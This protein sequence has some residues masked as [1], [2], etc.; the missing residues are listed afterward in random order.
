[1][2]L[3][4]ISDSPMARPRA[5]SF[6]M[7]IYLANQTGARVMPH[8]C[9]RDR[10]VIALR[11]AILGGYINGIRDMLVITG[12]PVARDDRG[13]VSGV[14][15]F[16]SIKLMEYIS[17]MNTEVFSEE[18]YFFGGAL[19]YAGVNIE[20]IVGRMK[21]KMEAGCSY[22]L[23]QPVY[24]DEDIERVR[25]LKRRTGAKIILGLMPLVSYKNALFM[26]NEMPGISVPNLIVNQ[27]HPDMSREEAETIAEKVCVE[28][29][30][31]AM[32]FAD[33]Y[34][35]MTPFN[36][37]TLVNRIIHDLRMSDR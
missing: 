18:P 35:L 24:S 13:T 2:D 14:F 20:A 26:K 3:I 16:N 28:I 9:C 15:D 10:N 6:E 29:G 7:G 30:K 34:Y 23:T 33:G 32:D 25:E 37:V 21:K 22:F 11:S 27:Y 12:D 19:N 36:R 5:E 31:K 4:T 17:N 1:M 8:V